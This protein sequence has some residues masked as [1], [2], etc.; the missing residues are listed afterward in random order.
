MRKKE[1]LWFY[2]LISPWVFGFITLT[3]GSMIYSFVISLTNW[4]LFTSPVFVGPDNYIRLFTEDKIFWKTVFNTLYY[5]FISVPLGMLFS[6][7]IVYFLNRPIKGSAFYRTLYYIPATVPGVASALL[8]KWLLAPDAG[9]IN[10]FLALFGL[11]GPAWLLEPEW[12]KPAL[13][14]MSLWV[15]GANITLLIAGIRSIPVEFYEAAELDGA[16]PIAQYYLITLPLLSPVIFFNII[17][18]MIGALQ[19]F[20]QIYIMTNTGGA[21]MGGPNNASMMIVPY[22]FNNGFRFYKMGYASAIAWILFVLVM[23]LTLLVFRSSSAWVYYET[24]V[25]KS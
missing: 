15:V 23:I 21:T 11:D 20:T 19:I 14:L 2:L 18:G 3:L 12:V 10:R 13:I 22:L 17:S 25:R 5:A 1:A 4:D 8:F 9:M 7:F 24:E 6:L 16:S